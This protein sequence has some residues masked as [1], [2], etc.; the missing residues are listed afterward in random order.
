MA[1]I[2]IQSYSTQLT[3]I[4]FQEFSAICHSVEKALKSK[5]CLSTSDLKTH[6]TTTI[7][8]ETHNLLG[9]I[10]F[11]CTLQ[12]FLLNE[13]LETEVLLPNFTQFR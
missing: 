11:W 9:V 5:M 13:T 1:G 10:Q 8:V 12:V 3:G 6:T 2:L 7:S 4:V